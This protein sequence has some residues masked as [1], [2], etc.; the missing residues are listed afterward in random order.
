MS[1]L[2]S[3]G[4]RLDIDIVAANGFTET[5]EFLDDVGD[6]IDITGQTVTLTIADGDGKSGRFD[7]S[8]KPNVSE[9]TATITDASNGLCR[10]SVPPEK[11]RHLYGETVSYAIS[12]TVSG[13]ITP[14]IW[15]IM[16]IVEA[17]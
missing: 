9:Y 13:I 17:V 2:D 15:G 10:F 14:Q 5:I 16:R 8:I 3:R 6:P 12:R 1:R 4:A 7:A 11:F